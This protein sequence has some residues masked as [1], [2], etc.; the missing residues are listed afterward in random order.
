MKKLNKYPFLT[1][2]AFLCIWTSCEE[3]FDSESDTMVVDTTFVK[4]DSIDAGTGMI[5]AEGFELVR[6]RC[7]TCHSSKLITQNLASRDGWEDMIRWMQ[8]T[9]KLPDLG[10][11]E[12]PILDYLAAHYAPEDQGRRATLVIEEWYEL[13]D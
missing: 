2:I 6:Q 5:V 3:S 10:E 11:A 8:E 7:L 12:D 13:A 1:L 4:P 9:Q